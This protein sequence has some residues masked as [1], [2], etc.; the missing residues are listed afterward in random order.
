MGKLNNKVAI[1]TGASRGIGQAIAELFAKE[2]ARVI[3][4]ARTLHE[5]DH[6]LL[7]GSLESTVAGIKKAGGEAAAVTCDVSSEAECEKLFAETHRIYGPADV[8]VNNAALTYFIPVKDYETRKWMR[9]FSINLHAPFILSKLAL[10]DMVPRKS[11]AILNISSAAAVGPGRGP[12]KGDAIIRGAV[13]YG[14][15]KAAMERMTQGLAEE[16]YEDSISVTCLSPSVV[17]PTPGAVHFHLIEGVDDPERRAGRVDGGLCAAAGDRAARQGHR[18]GDLQSSGAASN[19]ECLKSRAAVSASIARAA[20]T[21]RSNHAERTR[22][23]AAAETRARRHGA[24]RPRA[25]RDGADARWR[26]PRRATSIIRRATASASKASFPPFWSARPTTRAAAST[27]CPGIH[28]SRFTRATATSASRRMHAGRFASEGIWHMMT[29]DV[30]TASTPR[31]WL[32]EQPWSDGGFGMIGTSYVGGTQH[33][34]ALSNPPGLKTLVPVDAVVDAGYFGMRNGGAL[35]LRFTNWIFSMA[36]PEG[37]RASRDPATRA[38]LEECAR[39]VRRYISNL[40]IRKGATP[41]RLAPEYEEWIVHA[42]SHGEND[43]YWKQPGFGVTHNVDAYKDIPVYLVGGWYD[44]WARQTTMSYAALSKNK[45]GP[46][47]MILGPW[48]HGS[49][50]MSHARRHRLR[51]ECRDRRPRISPALVRP[52]AEGNSQRRRERRAGEN[53]RDGRRQRGNRTR[54]TPSARR[55]VARRARVAARAHPLHALL[56]AWRRHLE[57]EAPREASSSTATTTIRAIR[58]R[59]SAATSPRRWKSCS[60]ARGIRKAA[61]TSGIAPRKSASPRAAT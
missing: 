44:S 59:A 49:H 6:K 39:N 61:R 41:L 15:E 28:G 25:R 8:L 27:A 37:S 7:P 36:A 38:A 19:T 5:G 3:C 56:L 33:A 18:M 34:M 9:S 35:E 46:V 58:C 53:F 22:A 42:M 2:G 11:G 51:R 31:E 1:V 26:P 29:D 40:P 13:C 17:V 55:R 52:L 4:T 57:L 60:R 45:R 30:P 16:V 43:A 23:A 50:M 54:R 14:A 10:Q 20:D 24:V 21:V 12:Y 47:R 48:I 32:V